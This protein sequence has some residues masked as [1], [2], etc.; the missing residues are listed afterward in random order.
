MTRMHALPLYALLI[1]GT[2]ATP[3]MAQEATSGAATQAQSWD[4]LD[5]DSDGSLSKTE[6]AAHPALTSVFDEADSNS[7]GQL[8]PTEYRD[9]IAS[10][11][12][13]DSTA[14]DATQ[15]TNEAEPEPEEERPG[16]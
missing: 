7:D 5:T 3:A 8:S 9:F 6:A 14:A 13:T 12:A 16:N 4:A 15:P 1:A 2:A 11:Q 10:R